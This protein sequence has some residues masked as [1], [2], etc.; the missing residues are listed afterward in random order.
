MKKHL[1]IFLLAALFLGCSQDDS[2]D[3]KSNKV[4][5]K[6]VKKSAEKDEVLICLDEGSKITCK[7]MTKRVNK[8][9]DV[10]FEWESPNGKDDR[11]RDMVLPAGHAS[12]FDSRDKKGRVKGVWTV[13][14]EIGD[15]EVSTTFTIQ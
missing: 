9:R 11:E 1:S 10:E 13:E 8:D 12:I 4:I 2:A 14:V 15:E 7:L 3:K 6:E 5:K